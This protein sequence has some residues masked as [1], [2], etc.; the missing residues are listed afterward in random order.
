MG[1]FLF[2]FSSGGTAP[3]TTISVVTWP[4]TASFAFC[5]ALH[6]TL[7]LLLVGALRYFETYFTAHTTETAAQGLYCAALFTLFFTRV[8]RLSVRRCAATLKTSTK[9]ARLRRHA[10]KHLRGAAHCA[11]RTC[12]RT[13]K[14]LPALRVHAHGRHRRRCIFAL[15]RGCAPL[16]L[17]FRRRRHALLRAHAALLLRRRTATRR[18]APAA[19]TCAPVLQPV[20]FR[21]AF[22]GDLCSAFSFLCF[23][24]LSLTY[25]GVL[26]L[27][28]HACLGAS[29]FTCLLEGACLCL[30]SACSLQTP[31][32]VYGVSVLLGDL[33]TYAFYISGCLAFLRLTFSCACHSFLFEMCWL[34]AKCLFPFHAFFCNSRCPFIFPFF[35]VWSTPRWCLTIFLF[36]SL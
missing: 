28:L 30:G 3:F 29:L 4:G 15:R 7:L 11:A 1:D 14:W 23:S 12:F 27:F 26:R 6:V 13:V 21:C 2:L 35:A 19:C 10:T 5:A 18:T 17:R 36:L 25:S 31:L 16:S 22:F 9:C 8:W 32:F 24:S 20:Y 34:A 33:H